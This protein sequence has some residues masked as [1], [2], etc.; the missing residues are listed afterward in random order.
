MHTKIVA[1]LHKTVA[2][3]R[4]NVYDLWSIDLDMITKLMILPNFKVVFILLIAI[5]P[6]WPDFI[7]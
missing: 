6:Y 7:V 1:K 3:L 4:L 2:D 5:V